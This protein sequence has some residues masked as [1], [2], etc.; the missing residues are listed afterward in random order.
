MCAPT[1][2]SPTPKIKH[3][4]PLNTETMLNTLSRSDL[5]SI[6]KHLGIPV[7]KSKGDTVV[8]IADAIHSGKAYVK[9]IVHISLPPPAALAAVNPHAK[10]MNLLIKKFRN[11]RTDKILVPVPAL[12]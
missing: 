4:N 9:T 10:G 2:K 7:G 12:S 5:S 1:K 3:V 6:A 11:Y 8:N